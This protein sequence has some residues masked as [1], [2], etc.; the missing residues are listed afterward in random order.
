MLD[1]VPPS[2]LLHVAVRDVLKGGQV[3][4]AVLDRLVKATWVNKDSIFIGDLFG[5]TCS[6]S[7]FIRGAGR[8]ILAD[9]ASCGGHGKGEKGGKHDNIDVN[10]TDDVTHDITDDVTYTSHST[11]LD[12]SW[13]LSISNDAL[14]TALPYLIKSI[15]V[16]TDTLITSSTLSFCLANCNMKHTTMLISALSNRPMLI[17]S[18]EPLLLDKIQSLLAGN[19]DGEYGDDDGE[20]DGTRGRA[21]SVEV[22]ASRG[23]IVAG[24]MLEDGAT[25][26]SL[27]QAV[28]LCSAIGGKGQEIGGKSKAIDAVIGRASAAQLKAVLMRAG[29]PYSVHV[30]AAKRLSGVSGLEENVR[31]R[32]G[33]ILAGKRRGKSGQ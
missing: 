28:R 20:Y 22:A 19:H 11:P 13:L 8:R 18:L 30:A 23:G 31:V 9:I 17:R 6:N 1:V 5:L 4:A 33:H 21:L 2:V 12:Y 27:D 32:I 29:V 10:M 16:E 7:G 14:F 26:L 15:S 3:D 25:W 24:R